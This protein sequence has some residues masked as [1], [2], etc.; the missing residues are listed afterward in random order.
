[1][2]Y[3]FVLEKKDVSLPLLECKRL[4]VNSWISKNA[5]L[6]IGSLLRSSGKF[7]DTSSRAWDEDFDSSGDNSLSLHENISEGSVQ[8]L[9]HAEGFK[10]NHS[11]STNYNALTSVRRLVI[12][13]SVKTSTSHFLQIFVY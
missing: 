11:L 7:D 8:N 9:K 10:F 2:I 4:T 5:I 6:G 1:M 3:V 13:V 12:Y